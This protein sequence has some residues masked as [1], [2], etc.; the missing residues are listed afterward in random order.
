MVSRFKIELYVTIVVWTVCAV[1]RHHLYCAFV[2]LRSP[3]KVRTRNEWFASE[4]PDL[5]LVGTYSIWILRKMLTACY[6]S[7]QQYENKKAHN[8]YN[9]VANKFRSCTTINSSASV[10]KISSVYYVSHF[11]TKLIPSHT[12]ITDP[13]QVLLKFGS[14]ILCKLYP[15]LRPA[16]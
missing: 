13:S 7:E 12:D 10:A 6:S 3:P 14:Y 1:P 16:D 5:R 11:R 4:S 15:A 2:H 8:T 9:I